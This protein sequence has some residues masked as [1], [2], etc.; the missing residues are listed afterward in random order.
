MW[1]IGQPCTEGA[2]HDM[3]AR[4]SGFPQSAAALGANVSGAGPLLLS[5]FQCPA[6]QGS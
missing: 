3:P 6:Q 5:F 2:I 4:T 1:N